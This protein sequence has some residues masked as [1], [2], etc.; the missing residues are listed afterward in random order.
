MVLGLGVPVREGYGQ[1]EGTALATYTP[2]GDVRIGTV[3]T[4][5]PGVELRIADDGE[6]LVRRPGIFAGY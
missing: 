1:T 5:L 6:I 3:G 4:A 2:A